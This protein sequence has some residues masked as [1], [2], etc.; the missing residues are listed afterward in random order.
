M[1]ISGTLSICAILSTLTIHVFA[2]AVVPPTAQNAALPAQA[3]VPHPPAQALQP[4]YVALPVYVKVPGYAGGEPSYQQLYSPANTRTSASSP[5]AQLPATMG[6][7]FPAAP[8]IQVSPAPPALT[9]QPPVP[10]QTQ[11][12]PPAQVQAAPV[13]AQVAPAQAAPPAP[14]QVQPAAAVPAAAAAAGAASGASVSSSAGLECKC[15]AGQTPTMFAG[16]CICGDCGKV[17]PGVK[18]YNTSCP[19]EK[20]AAFNLG[21]EKECKEIE[22]TEDCEFFKKSPGALTDDYKRCRDQLDSIMDDCENDAKCCSTMVKP[23]EPAPADD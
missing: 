10:P 12:S 1:R 6:G 2:A 15:P 4:E 20:F 21:L 13:N 14:A 11:V 19:D 23:G 3:A 18:S 17:S 8:G 22:N 5:G 16:L 9:G 7:Q